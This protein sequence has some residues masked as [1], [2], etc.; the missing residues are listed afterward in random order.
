MNVYWL[1]R[2]EDDEKEEEEEE[3]KVN[4]SI[5]A[6]EVEKNLCT[7]IYGRTLIVLFSCLLS[8]TQTNDNIERRKIITRKVMNVHT[9]TN[10]QM[11]HGKKETEHLWID[12]YVYINK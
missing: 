8:E 6:T 2:A 1:S 7:Q 12:I 3:K 10:K 9:H 4:N 5:A 11:D